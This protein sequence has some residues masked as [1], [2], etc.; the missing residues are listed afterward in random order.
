M[1]HENIRSY[2]AYIHGSGQSHALRIRMKSHHARDPLVVKRQ[3]CLLD[4]ELARTKFLRSIYG[5]FGKTVTEYSV[6]Y[7]AYTRF[8]PSLRMW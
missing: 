6:I 3:W 7:G 1:K 4:V 5:I 8:W 2:T